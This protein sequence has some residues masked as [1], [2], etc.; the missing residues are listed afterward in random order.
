MT[1]TDNAQS[2]ASFPRG[3]LTC[4]TCHSSDR[5][6]V[7][8]YAELDALHYHVVVVCCDE[9]AARLRRAGVILDYIGEVAA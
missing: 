1:A 2:S 7:A 5:D 3:T 4:P 8:E 6:H 9:C